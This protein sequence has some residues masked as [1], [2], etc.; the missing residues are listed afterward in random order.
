LQ[1][2]QR[3]FMVQQCFTTSKGITTSKGSKLRMRKE[4]QSTGK[5]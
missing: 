3:C 4:G 1:M 5:A 2:G